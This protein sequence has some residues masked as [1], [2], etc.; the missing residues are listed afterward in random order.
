MPWSAVEL[1]HENKADIVDI[2]YTVYIKWN[3]EKEKMWS[4]NLRGRICIQVC[5]IF[6]NYCVYSS[7]GNFLK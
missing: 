4:Q 2:K 7:T 1:Q 5:N 6:N 3:K